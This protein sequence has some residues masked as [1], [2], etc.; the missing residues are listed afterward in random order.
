MLFSTSRRVILLRLRLME[1]VALMVRQLSREIHVKFDFIY[2]C[3]K[4]Y[5]KR[6]TLLRSAKKE[7]NRKCNLLCLVFGKVLPAFMNGLEDALAA[8]AAAATEH[9]LRLRY[10]FDWFCGS[11]DI[12]RVDGED[13]ASLQKFLERASRPHSEHETMFVRLYTN[14]ASN[15]QP[16]LQFKA[17]VEHMSASHWCLTTREGAPIFTPTS[18]TTGGVHVALL[19]RVQ[20]RVLRAPNRL[21][22]AGL[23][24]RGQ[25]AQS[26]KKK[27]SG[28]PC[29]AP[30]R[31]RGECQVGVTS[32]VEGCKC[33][34]VCLL[35]TVQQESHRATT[36]QPAGEATS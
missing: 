26:A 2:N 16:V 25:A 35:R 30:L 34:M 8:A 32:I 7:E 18:S 23:Q 31:E 9:L 24:D 15:A 12:V 19:Q 14:G 1:T 20:M 36:S 10:H 11:S 6:S 5:L 33:C 21:T 27:T 17:P 13:E 29:G 22:A 3:V 28:Q 4:I